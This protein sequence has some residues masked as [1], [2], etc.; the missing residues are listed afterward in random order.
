MADSGRVVYAQSQASLDAAFPRKTDVPV[1][2]LDYAAADGTDQTTNLNAAFAAAAGGEISFPRGG[3]FK[4]SSELT[5]PASIKINGYGSTIDFSTMPNATALG[6]K[7]GL[8]AAGA[9]GSDIAISNAISQWSRVVTGIA[10][11]V[12]LAAGDL[13]LLENDERPVPGMSRTDRDKGELSVIASVD[14][15]TQITLTTGALF[16]YGTTGLKLRKVTPAEDITIEGLTLRMRGVGSAHNGIQV[17]YG[18]NVTI[19]DVTV[20]GAE[21]TGVSLNTVWNGKVSHCQVRDCT[22]SG[23]LGN[24]GYGVA[25]LEASRHCVVEDNHFHNCRHF[26]AGGGFWPA[27]FIDVKGNQ[28]QNASDAA[29]DCHEPCFYWTFTKN[30]AVGVSSGFAI[31][32]QYVTLDGN[33]VTD[34]QGRAYRSSTFDGVTEQRGIRMVNNRASHCTFG[35]EVDGQA[36][37]AE[38]NCLKIDVEI[39]GN[40]LRDCGSDSI[41][42]RHFDG[43]KVN[44]NNVIGSTS[45]AV[46]ILGLSGT[47]SKYLECNENK[48]RDA[49]A[50]AIKIQFVDDLQIVGGQLINTF[51]TG[52][53]MLT[54][55]RTLISGLT[56]RTYN[57][58]GIF[59]SAGSVHAVT[60]PNIT[61]GTGATFDCLRF[62]AT[63][64][65]AVSG[66]YFAGPRY[67]VYSTTT[68]KV[69][70]TGVNAYDSVGSA[71]VK[72]SSDATTKVVA[73]NLV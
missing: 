38:P 17:R 11:T 6:Q 28:G 1:S 53:E 30:I 49:G 2:V 19:R 35:L 70:I 20:I 12:T 72:V 43:A 7:I 39:V 27:A 66:G 40:I 4:A 52:V 48:V 13:I 63:S 10:S 24:T 14:S 22:S 60:G 25:I 64:Q 61:G 33:M 8:K 65:V 55:N 62:S 44:G 37:G 9:I 45:H 32:G 34:S 36:A 51:T 68:D 3:V 58:N 54:C 15:S 73:N 31:R 5:I 21:D 18:R 47:Q 69:I 29:Y 57:S 56:I 71:G 23:T 42:L 41:L 46:L 59:V 50:D 16:A 67:G 26:V